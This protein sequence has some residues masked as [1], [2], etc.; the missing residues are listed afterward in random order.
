MLHAASP[1]RA[2]QKMTDGTLE[3]FPV[4]SE[5]V[6]FSQTVRRVNNASP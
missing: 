6:E 2:E 1:Q 3:E 4:V 5:A